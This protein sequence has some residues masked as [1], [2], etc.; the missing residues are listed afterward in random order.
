VITGIFSDDPSSI[1][2]IYVIGLYSEA[3]DIGFQGA[4]SLRALDHCISSANQYF[5]TISSAYA[6]S[7][8]FY[9]L[10]NAREPYIRKTISK[11]NAPVMR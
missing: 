3:T 8:L 11:I 10:L 6:S 4:S 1:Y 9:A 7:G 5:A 2:I